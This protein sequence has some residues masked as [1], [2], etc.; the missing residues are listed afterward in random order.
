MQ[1]AVYGHGQWARVLRALALGVDMAYKIDHA[2][3]WTTWENCA[4][5]AVD[6]IARGRYLTYRSLRDKPSDDT[7]T[8]LPGRLW[9][10]VL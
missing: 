9:R 1:P 8:G 10:H 7:V 5:R 6:G 3:Q 4:S 2:E